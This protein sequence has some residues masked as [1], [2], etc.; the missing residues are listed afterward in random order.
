[1]PNLS[2]SAAVTG[3]P[4][5]TIAAEDSARAGSVAE[6]ATAAA[7]ANAAAIDPTIRPINSSKP[8]ASQSHFLFWERLVCKS[9]ARPGQS[10]ALAL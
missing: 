1:M 7:T 9:I 3:S 6:I 5:D 10:A 2:A 8:P 4:C